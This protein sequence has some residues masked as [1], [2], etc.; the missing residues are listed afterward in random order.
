MYINQ[1]ITK[2]ICY[3]SF[4]SPAIRLYFRQCLFNYCVMK[5]YVFLV[6][7]LYIFN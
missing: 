3:N 1:L 2:R 4:F 7:L 6:F 5:I